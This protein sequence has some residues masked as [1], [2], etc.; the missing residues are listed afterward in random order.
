LEADF[1]RYYRIDLTEEGFTNQL[2]WRRFMVL[3]RGLPGDSAFGRWLQD[4]ENRSLAEWSED[5]V[6]DE[7]EK[8]KERKRGG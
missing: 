3:V 4:K 7:I 1:W 8:I 2:S 5:S 6:A